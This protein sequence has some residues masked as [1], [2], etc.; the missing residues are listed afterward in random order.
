MLIL[1][2]PAPCLRICFLVGVALAPQPAPAATDVICSPFVP[3]VVVVGD[4]AHDASCDAQTIQD[5]IAA[6]VCPNTTVYLTVGGTYSGQHVTIQGKSLSLVGSSAGSCSTLTTGATAAATTTA[7]TSPVTTISGDGSHPVFTISDASN[8][9]FQYV[10]ITGGGGGAGTYG[11]GIQFNGSGSLTLDTT[12]IEGNNAGYGAGMAIAGIGGN[13][14]VTLKN[15]SLILNNTAQNDGGGV[16]IEGTARLFMLADASTIA[17]NHAD[18]GTGGGIDVIG[19]ARVDIAAPGTPLTGAVSDNTAANG[20][21]IGVIASSGGDAVARLF[22]AD[23]NNP[24]QVSQNV[25]SGKGGAFYLRSSGPYYAPNTAELCV[26]EFRIRDNSAAAGAAIYNDF[27]PDDDLTDADSVY[28]NPAGNCGPEST[29]SLGAVACA[30]GTP[31]N[32]VSDNSAV[33]TLGHATAGSVIEL[34]NFTTLSADRFAMRGNSAARMVTANYSFQAN[35][36]SNCLIADNDSAHELIDSENA[37]QPFT[38]DNCTLA[39]NNIANGYV[40]HA[41]D[42]FVVTHSI[43]YQPGVSTF[44]YSSGCCLDAGYTLSTEVLTFPDGSPFITQ[45]NAPL[46]VDAGNAD[47]GKRDYH[48]RAYKQDGLVTAS[49]AIDFAPPVAGDDR[50]LDGA[51]HDQD[52]PAVADFQGDRDLGCYEAQPITDRVFAEAFGDPVSL[53]H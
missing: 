48:L 27:S 35:G 19:P 13:L 9:T 18:N 15:Y 30:P 20:A 10:D 4:K 34:Y 39:Q 40:F 43:V 31:C 42:S 32:E 6:A 46:F 53:L 51:P 24:V 26:F 12:T 45:S 14:A 5:G 7:P 41:T 49:P 3:H 47:V 1:S 28:F 38:V 36:L 23:P 17:F 25:A 52:V 11:G 29:A 2:R 16:H 37:G 50:D 22:S 33:D 21:G 8:V 44:D